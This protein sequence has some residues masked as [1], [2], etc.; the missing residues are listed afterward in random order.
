MAVNLDRSLTVNAVDLS[1]Y[2]RDMELT[3]GYEAATGAETD[4]DT[5]RWSERGMAA[6]GLTV[7]LKQ[8]Y[9]AGT[10]DATISALPATFTVVVM[11]VATGGV[12]ATNPT[13]TAT[14]HLVDYNPE[15]GSIGEIKYCSA[16]FALAAGT[17][18]VRATS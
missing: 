4:G 1:A 9:G 7:Q 17:G 8:D 3:D 13:R 10:V 2:I 16:T 14:M 11:P 18:W 5:A 6:G 15:A 12:G